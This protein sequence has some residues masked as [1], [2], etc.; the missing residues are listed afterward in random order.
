MRYSF[1]WGL[2]LG[3]AFALVYFIF[4][5]QLLQIFTD[6]SRVVNLAMMLYYWILIAPFVN[7]VCFIW[8]GV[9]IGA[10]ATRPMVLSMILA[11]VVIFLPTY[12]LGVGPLGNDALWLAMTLFMAT[13]GIALSFFARRSIFGPARVSSSGEAAPN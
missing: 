11:T 4:D 7:S 8:D 5:R 1:Y 6:D 9:F 10:T 3:A 12:Y 2:G 13:R